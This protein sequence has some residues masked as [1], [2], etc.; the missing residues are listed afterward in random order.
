MASGLCLD[1]M[2]QKDTIKLEFLTVNVNLLVF[3]YLHNVYN[4]FLIIDH[5]GKYPS[6]K[7][8]DKKELD[9]LL[10]NALT[11]QPF[12]PVKELVLQLLDVG[13]P[14]TIKDQVIAIVLDCVI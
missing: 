6:L 9:L 8:T 4:P 14:V 13:V 11:M 10:F 2:L 1:L 7:E 12:G 5:M 3:K